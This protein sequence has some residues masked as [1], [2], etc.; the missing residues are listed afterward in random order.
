M[1]NKDKNVE[2]KSPSLRQAQRDALGDPDSYRDG[3]ASGKAF[4]ILV[5]QQKMIGD[6]LTSSL[7]CENLKLNFPEAEIHYLINRFTLPVVECHPCVDKFIIFESDYRKSKIRFYKLLKQIARQNYTHVFDAYAK[8]ESLLISRFSKAGHRYGFKKPYSKFYYTKTVKINKSSN[9][10]AGTAIENRLRLLKLMPDV[11]IHKNKP[12]IYLTNSEIE[13][14]KFKLNNYDLKDKHCIMISA[15]GSDKTKTYPLEFMAELLDY[16]SA[17]SHSRL[18]LNY[19]PSQQSEI[20]ELINYCDS[21][22][23]HK[24]ITDIE[25]K[26]LRDFISICQQ[27]SAIVGNEGGAINIAK[28]L[29]VPSF[30]I[31]SPWI[32]KEGWNSFEINH[33]NDSVHLSDYQNDLFIKNE[34]KYIKKNVDKFYNKLKPELIKEKLS[35]FLKAYV[36]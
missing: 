6:V 2:N 13:A 25:M 9:S 15:L 14:A 4:K 28:A 30:S 3:E 23:Q 16:M 32:I 21:K 24:I 34:A 1:N 27:C 8:L 10:E 35:V 22:T 7:I 18:I 33:P 12:K 29:D 11:I 36:N 20:E 17:Q 31:F 5:I 19:M 26:G